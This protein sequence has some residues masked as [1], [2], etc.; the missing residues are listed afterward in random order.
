MSEDCHTS[1]TPECCP[2]CGS[3]VKATRLTPHNQLH[4]SG[5]SGKCVHNWHWAVTGTVAPNPYYGRER[6]T[7]NPNV[8]ELTPYD[9]RFFKFCAIKAE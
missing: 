4:T 8:L 7:R 9:R 3:T 6:M 1:G 5:V 2:A